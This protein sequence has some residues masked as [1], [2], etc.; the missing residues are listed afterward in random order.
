M[1]IIRIHV[2]IILRS[3]LASKVLFALCNSATFGSVTCGGRL[4]CLLLS[5]SQLAWV[6]GRC[7][8]SVVKCALVIHSGHK[9]HTQAIQ[10]LHSYRRLCIA[11]AWS[12]SQLL[13]CRALS[14]M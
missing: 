10:M 11:E 14:Y 1:Y 12:H 2:N 7:F 8:F 9:H 4:Q 6:G 3:Y 13:W 5:E